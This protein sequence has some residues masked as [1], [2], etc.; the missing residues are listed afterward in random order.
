MEREAM[1]SREAVV[2]SEEA[3]HAHLEREET[4]MQLRKAVVAPDIANKDFDDTFDENDEDVHLVKEDNNADFLQ[5]S[6]QFCMSS[7]PAHVR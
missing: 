6:H 3:S 4:N 2:A 5:P 1:E 7:S